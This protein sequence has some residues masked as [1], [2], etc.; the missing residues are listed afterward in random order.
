MHRRCL[1]FGEPPAAEPLQRRVSKAQH[2]KQ[3]I[4]LWPI[5][6]RPHIITKYNN[7]YL[8]II[9]WPKANWPKANTLLAMLSFAHQTLFGCG[10]IKFYIL[11]FTIILFY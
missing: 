9:L 6:L 4:G 8:K 3:C 2:C 7:F 1:A 5:G 10:P 11:K